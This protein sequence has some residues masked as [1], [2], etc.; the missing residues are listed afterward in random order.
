MASDDKPTDKWCT[1]CKWIQTPLPTDMIA[2]KC[3]NPKQ[4]KNLVTGEP[5]QQTCAWH[6]A[7]LNYSQACTGHG[8]WYEARNAPLDSGPES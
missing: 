7:M 8:L 4:G 3:T 6:R 1:R 5:R 2:V